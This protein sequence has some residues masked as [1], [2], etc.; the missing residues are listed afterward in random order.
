[1]R[2]GYWLFFSFT[3]LVSLVLPITILFIYRHSLTGLSLDFNFDGISHESDKWS[4]FGSLLSGVFTLSGAIATLMTLIFAIHQNNKL[5]D[6]AEKRSR[7]DAATAQKNEIFVDLQKE[8]ITFE[9]FRIH[10][11]AFNELLDRLERDTGHNYQFI[12]R[13]ELYKKIFP[14]NTFSNVRIEENEVSS[15]GLKD[16]MDLSRSMVRKFKDGNYVSDARG[17]VDDIISLQNT[18]LVN[19]IRQ[20]NEGDVTFAGKY[21]IVN[22]ADIFSAL[23]FYAATINAINLFCNS[24]VEIRLTDEINLPLLVISLNKFTSN[25]IN[26]K[27]RNPSYPYGYIKSSKINN[28]VGI[29]RDFNVE[30]SDP[31]KPYFKGIA[32]FILDALSPASIH[33]SVSDEGF[34]LLLAS[35]ISRGESV[36]SNNLQSNASLD[37]RARKCIQSVKDIRDKSTR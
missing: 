18:L 21:I 20:T 37:A 26:T 24:G 1:M 19:V 22:E 16:L 33:S 5:S 3:A 29:Y 9:K 35:V 23:S 30:D 12:S 25:I 8:K 32:S 15:V 7:D 10:Q 14:T 4:D 2:K 36:I 6:E 28:M 13:Y 17:L 34:K 11:Q 31:L 27:S